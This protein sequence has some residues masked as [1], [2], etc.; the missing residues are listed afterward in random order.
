MNHIS[1]LE[2]LKEGHDKVRTPLAKCYEKR[3]KQV[4][5]FSKKL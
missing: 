2:V 3:R 4:L 5:N 1:V